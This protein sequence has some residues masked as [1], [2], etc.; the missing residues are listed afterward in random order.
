MRISTLARMLPHPETVC[1]GADGH[2]YAGLALGSPQGRGPIVRI[3]PDDGTAQRFTDTGGRILGLARAEDG[4]VGCDVARAEL[5]RISSD[6]TV[7]AR[8]G[9]ADGRRLL[10]PNGCVVDAAGGVWFTDSG[11]ATAGEPTGSVC[12]AAPGESDTCRVAAADLV[13]PNGIGI[14]PDG[15]T[16]YV[17]LT[18]D[19]TLLAFDV[20]GPGRLSGRRTVAT[21]GALSAGP[22]G[23]TVAPDGTC[24]LAVTRG[25]RVVR[26]TPD[27][28][29]DTLIEAPDLL[30]MPSHAALH[31][32]RLLV[33]SL[34]GDTITAV[35]LAPSGVSAE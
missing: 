27:G 23:L 18:R 4:L 28:R 19:D 24:Y 15:G 26:I 35:D 11:T 10:R 21:G 7:T 17:S 8:I 5:V 31:G 29:V 20:A 16:L 34:F 9:T 3:D 12:Y 22:D 2:L 1:V 13:Y 30:R 25:S 6:G 14:S 33:P 32:D